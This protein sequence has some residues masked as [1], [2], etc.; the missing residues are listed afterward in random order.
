M[1]KVTLETDALMVPVPVVLLS[2]ASERGG[3]NVTTVA[4]VSVACAIPPMVSVALRPERLS[5]ALIRESGE[6]VLN[7]PPASLLRAVDVCG[8]VSGREIDKFARARLTPLPSLKVAAPAITECPVH[9]ECV[10]RQAIVLGSHVLLLS[11]VVA[12]RADE[13]VVEDG[14]ILTGRI[15]PLAYDPFGGDYWT[16][17]EVVA[18]H[19]FSEGSMPDPPP[20]KTV[21]RQQREA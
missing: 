4:W 12:L 3:M 2:T 20:R 18:H 19:G 16:L 5:H 14:G 15:A 17:K 8:V 9:L 10:L 21:R 1:A 7:I 13:E 11:E 6:F